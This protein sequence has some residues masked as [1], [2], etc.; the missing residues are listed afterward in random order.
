MSPLLKSEGVYAPK[1]PKMLPTETL[2]EMFFDAMEAALTN[3]KKKEKLQH[4]RENSPVSANIRVREVMQR[5]SEEEKA[6]AIMS[7]IEKPAVM[8][9]LYDL[10]FLDRRNHRAGDK[11]L[12]NQVGESVHIPQLL[13]QLN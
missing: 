11:G 13:E 1:S 10:M 8:H 9:S 6:K 4:L 7:F 12:L 3:Q 2:Q 5:A